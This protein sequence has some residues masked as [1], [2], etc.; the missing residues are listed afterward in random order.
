[1]VVLAQVPFNSVIPAEDFP[2][3]LL[4]WFGPR[5]EQRLLVKL[6]RLGEQVAE[7][8]LLDFYHVRLECADRSRQTTHAHAD[9]PFNAETGAH[10]DL[11]HTQM[12]DTTCPATPE[13]QSQWFRE[14]RIRH[15]EDHSCQIF[16][17]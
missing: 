11:D 4:R 2:R 3:R 10:Q 14:S 6:K 8:F 15:L 5:T 7:R 1:M 13:R 12:C 9:N 17:L 16:A